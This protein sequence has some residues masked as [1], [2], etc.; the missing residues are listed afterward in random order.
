MGKSP[1]PTDDAARSRV[2]S[3]IKSKDTSIEISLRKALW[4]SGVRYRKNYKKLPG[5][6]DIA[7]TK[8]QIAIFCDGEFWHGKGWGEKKPDI[9]SNH[10]YWMEKIER[11]MERD[12][13]TEWKLGSM[14]WMV[15]RFWGAEIQKDL[16]SCVNE[17][18]CAIIQRKTEIYD[19]SYRDYREDNYDTG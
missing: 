5:A 12:D 14:G 4:R 3:R 16:L 19:S 17:I 8:Y 2:M 10:G 13:K 15:L 9:K 1:A 11:N 18:H 6:P 7:I